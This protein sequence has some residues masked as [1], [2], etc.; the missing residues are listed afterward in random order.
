MGTR[1]VRYYH[2]KTGF[3]HAQANNADRKYLL[4]FSSLDRLREAIR[5]E[6]P[7]REVKPKTVHIVNYKEGMARMRAG[8]R[9]AKA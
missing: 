1:V 8:Q 5:P 2:D 4:T 7:L 6:I 3:V 9:R